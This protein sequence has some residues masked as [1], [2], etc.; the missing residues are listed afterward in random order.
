MNINIMRRF[1]RILYFLIETDFSFQQ[2]CS[3]I[4]L[5]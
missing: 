2:I 4:Q 5:N 1:E 3:E